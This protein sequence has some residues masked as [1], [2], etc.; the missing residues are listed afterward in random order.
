MNCMDITRIANSGSFARL[1]EAERAATEAHALTCRH[2]A[3]VWVAHARLA[4]L[5]VPPLPSELSLRCRT[6]STTGPRHKNSMRRLT[7]AGGL[8]V[9]AAAAASLLWY[10]VSSSPLDRSASVA[11]VAPMTTSAMETAV[12]PAIAGTAQ[13]VVLPGDTTATARAPAQAMLPL[14]PAP[15]AAPQDEKKTALVLQKVLQRHPELVQGPPVNDASIFFVSVA[16]RADG[17]VLYSAAELASP[18]AATEVSG[19]LSRMLPV[20]AGEDIFS[21]LD[22]GQQLSG[23]AAVRARV[24][25]RGVIISESFDLTRSNVRVREILGHKYDDLMTPPSS[26][27][28][29]LLTVFLSD[30]GRILREKVEHLTPENA[31]VV[32]DVGTGMRRE[33]A[34]ATRLGIDVERIGAIG[35]TTLEQGTPRTVVDPDGLKRVD[36]VRMLSVRYAWARRAD[37]PAAVREPQRVKEPETDI[38]LAAAL[39]V[40]EQLLPDAFSHAPPSFADK[41]RPVVVFTAKG[42]VIRA[43]WVQIRNGVATESLLQQLVPGMRTGRARSV[44]LT[45]K[46]GATALVEFAWAED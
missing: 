46:S 22:K 42:E 31:A 38:D 18:A 35:S 27:D 28:S 39:V 32:L 4:E 13:Q 29:N 7:L 17:T 26:D 1:D 2:C 11:A 30:D 44:R 5:R 10:R 20:E 16:M 33:E 34:I 23:G 6:L 37:E 14:V 24:F 36:G 25:L 21:F 40:V 12:K 9:L 3:P 15:T 43:G 45:N 8:V 41:S 19:R